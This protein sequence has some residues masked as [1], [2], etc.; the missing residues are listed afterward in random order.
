M[1]KHISYMSEKVRNYKLVILGDTAVGKSCVASRFVQDEF[2]EFQEPTIGAAFLTKKL[3]L[4]DKIIK[5]EIWDTAGQER[6]RSLAPMYYRGACAAII[7][8]DITCTQSFIGAKTWITELMHKADNNCIIALAGNKTDLELHRTVNKNDV[9]EYIKGTNIFHIEISAK[10]GDNIQNLFE[11][12]AI[13][14][15][16]VIESDPIYNLDEP[17]NIYFHK[18]RRES[19]C[20]N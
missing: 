9:E 7:V 1:S 13:K 5:F 17:N 2:Y 6:Y 15:P 3:D 19:C 8:Y 16:E 14:F 18:H 4:D 20:H 11:K 10:T 12:I